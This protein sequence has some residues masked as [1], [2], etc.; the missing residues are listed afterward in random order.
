[1]DG[2]WR[3]SPILAK[4]FRGLAKALVITAEMDVLKDEGV[5]YAKRLRD[6][7]VSVEEVEIKGAPHIVMQLDGI[8]EGGSEYNRVTVRALREALGR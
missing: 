7:G 2:D 3:V 8:L 6:E 5:A 1:M 4:T